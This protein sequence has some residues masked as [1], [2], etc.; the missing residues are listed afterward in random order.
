LDD[1]ETENGTVVL[2]P[3]SG[4][5]VEAVTIE[6]L[7]EQGNTTGIQAQSFGQPDKTSATLNDNLIAGGLWRFR[8]GATNTLAPGMYA[9]RA[10]LAIDSAAPGSG[11]WIGEVFSQDTPLKITLPSNEPDR[12]A[13]R[14]LTL[15]QDAILDDRLQDAAAGL[16]ALLSEQSDNVEAWMLRAVVAERAGNSFGALQ[17]VNEGQRHYAALQVGE[18]HIELHAIT[19]RLMKALEVQE[20]D[21]VSKPLGHWSWPPTALLTANPPPPPPSEMSPAQ[22]PTTSSATVHPDQGSTSST[23]A[24]TEPVSKATIVPTAEAVESDFLADPR[25]QW[26][27]AATA[28]SE[29]GQGRYDAVQATG[30]PNVTSY[31]DNPQ[32]WCHSGAVRQE[33]WLEVSFARPVVASELRVRQSYTPGTLS[34]VEAFADD[35]RAQVLWEGTDPNPYPKGRISWFVLRFPPPE[36][37]VQRVKLTLSIGRVPGWK[38]IDAVQLVADAP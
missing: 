26:A 32:A 35:G 37:P 18:P 33:E 16:D 9:I 4:S 20:L 12:R 38:Q 31:S 1:S 36:F 8:S 23:V 25:G 30:A 24:P 11:G 29:Y 19:E 6:I 3:A 28:S 17:C 7:D 22:G 14:A 13:Q 10:R 27:V 5:W 15:A 34:K 2:A 21:K